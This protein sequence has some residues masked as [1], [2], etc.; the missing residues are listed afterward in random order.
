[1]IPAITIVVI[2]I[3]IIVMMMMT[4]VLAQVEVLLAEDA[5]A[6]EVVQADGNQIN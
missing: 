2:A 1:M 5:L 6:E 3:A 4:T